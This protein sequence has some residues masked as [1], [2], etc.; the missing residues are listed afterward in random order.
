MDVFLRVGDFDGLA[1]QFPGAEVADGDHGRELA[2]GIHHRQGPHAAGGKV[3]RA[4][5]SGISVPQQTTLRGMT[6]STLVVAGL[7]PS[8]TMRCST[9]RSEQAP[10][11]RSVAVTTTGSM[12]CS[13]ICRAASRTVVTWSLL[14]LEQV[15]NGGYEKT[16]RQR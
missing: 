12:R 1:V 4:S 5:F 6:S 2:V 15:G 11:M 8:A 3:L 14:G 16:F 9:S 13:F 10:A 7:R